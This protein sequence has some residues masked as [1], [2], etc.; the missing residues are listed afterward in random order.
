MFIKTQMQAGDDSEILII[1]T[2]KLLMLTLLM[3]KTS[4]ILK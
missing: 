1:V 2:L 3:L 4:M